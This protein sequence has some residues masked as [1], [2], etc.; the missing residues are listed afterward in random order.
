MGSLH[1]SRFARAIRYS[2]RACKTLLFDQRYFTSVLDGEYKDD[3]GYLPW[4]TYTAIEALKNW[5]LSQKRIFE[6]G[7]GYSTLFW[8]SRCKELVSVEHHSSWHEKISHLAPKNVQLILAPINETKNDYHPSPET[9]VEFKTYAESI[10]NLGKFDVIVLDGYARSRMRYQ[11]AIA[12]LPHLTQGGII[13]LDNSDWLPATATF[14]RQAGLIEVDLS[15]PVPGNAQ[16]QT[17]SFFLS[18]DFDFQPA[19]L[20][21]P[22]MPVGGRPDNWER[23]L[24]EEMLASRGIKP[25]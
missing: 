22:R 1:I 7:S 21:E 4:F 13:I 3:E 24:E 9:L 12:A 8:A 20:R 16:T 5:D 18:R 23:A 2:A 25:E 15:G 17:T 11:C 6:Y 10:S 14:L 19:N